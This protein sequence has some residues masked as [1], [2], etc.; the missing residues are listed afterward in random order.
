MGQVATTKGDHRVVNAFLKGKH[1]DLRSSLERLAVQLAAKCQEATEQGV[2]AL[3][4]SA[5]ARGAA[6]VVDGI[7]VR[8]PRHA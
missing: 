2:L 7:V 1:D 6:R 8:V 4:R 3:L 5:I